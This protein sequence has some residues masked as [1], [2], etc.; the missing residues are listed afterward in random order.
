MP[1]RRRGAEVVNWRVEPF[2]EYD[3][4]AF[5]AIVP[6]VTDT[7]VVLPLAMFNVPPD[8]MPPV[9]IEPVAVMLCSPPSMV[10]LLMT[11]PPLLTV[12]V[13][14]R[15]P[16]LNVPPFSVPPV[17]EQLPPFGLPL[18]INTVSPFVYEGTPLGD[19]LPATLKL[20]VEPPQV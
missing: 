1:P 16:P 17:Q 13:H 11:M 20:P 14:W 2:Q 7:S 4:R 10:P 18:L 9:Q 8:M 3:S 15:T 6:P 5:A 19:Q 12:P